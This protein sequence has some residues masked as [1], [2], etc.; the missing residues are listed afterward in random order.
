MYHQV[1]H[2]CDG[3]KDGEDF[4]VPKTGGPTLF[5]ISRS[6][7]HE[8][9]R[10]VVVRRPRASFCVVALLQLHTYRQH[11]VIVVGELLLGEQTQVFRAR[12]EAKGR[13]HREEGTN[14]NNKMQMWFSDVAWFRPRASRV[15]SSRARKLKGHERRVHGWWKHLCESLRRRDVNSGGDPADGQQDVH[16]FTFPGR[17]RRK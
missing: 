1:S 6:R 13:F 16:S 2:I 10:D 5:G 12:V 17:R 4:F 9:S 7:V 8:K 11:V 3:W 15:F 14:G